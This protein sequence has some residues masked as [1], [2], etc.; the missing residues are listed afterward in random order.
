MENFVK[1]CKAMGDGT[2]FKI[3]SMLLQ[4][5]F[6]VNAIAHQLGV[7]QSA[8]SQHMRVLRE[9]GL[10]ESD[11]QGYFVHYSV[12]SQGIE[13]FRQDVERLFAPTEGDCDCC[14]DNG[15]KCC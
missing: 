4:K 5:S 3:L 7:S 10:V 8:V 13:Q 11:K 14:P 2:R 1:S 6:C 12:S 15:D 9:A